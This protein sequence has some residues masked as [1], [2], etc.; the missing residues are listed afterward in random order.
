MLT[1]VI[2]AG[3]H[4]RRAESFLANLLPAATAGYLR[5]LLKSG[6]ARVNGDEASPDTFLFSGDI[7]T[8]KESARTGELLR[9]TPPLLDLLYEDDHIMVVNKPGGLAMHKSAEDERNN[10]VEIGRRFFRERGIDCL[11]RPVNRLDRG[12]SG[13]V[14]MAKSSTAAG[15][16]GRFVKEEGL[17]KVYLALAEGSLPEEGT[18]TEPLDGKESETR[19]R[20]V[21]QGERHALVALFPVTGR[22]H[23]IRRHLELA[24]HPIPG[25]RRY[26]GVALPAFP[27]IPL[28]SFRTILLHPESRK[29]LTVCAPLPAAF[30]AL[31]ARETGVPEEDILRRAAE[32]ALS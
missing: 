30:L 11:P 12:T 8:L 19:F 21:F 9:G 24:G 27:G 26:G 22:T 23:Q 2:N 32:L 31:A 20:T 10:L 16:F 4:C 1:Y 7:V 6:Q 3:D 14:I 28:H 17:D 5:K 29:P 15:M 18:M 25:D 13:A